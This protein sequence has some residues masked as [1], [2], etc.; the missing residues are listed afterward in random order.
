MLSWVDAYYVNADAAAVGSIPN[1]NLTSRTQ[2]AQLFA[3]WQRGELGGSATV[4]GLPQ[5]VQ[6]LEPVF[7]PGRAERIGVTEVTRVSV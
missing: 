1:L 3:D 6:A 4:E 7:G 5:L 2:F